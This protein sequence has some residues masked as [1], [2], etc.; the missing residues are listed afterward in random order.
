METFSRETLLYEELE[1]SLIQDRS[2]N[3]CIF[4]KLR[5]LRIGKAEPGSFNH[6]EFPNL[7]SITVE[8]PSEAIFIFCCFPACLEKVLTNEI[9]INSTFR[10]DFTP[11]EESPLHPDE[12]DEVKQRN[13]TLPAALALSGLLGLALIRR[14]T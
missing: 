14:R 11:Q 3:R 7:T 1:L 2:F 13:F 8:D 5:T 10:E 4:P 6:C 9:S 12:H